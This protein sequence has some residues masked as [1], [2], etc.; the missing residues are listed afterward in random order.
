MRLNKDY[1]RLTFSRAFKAIKRKSQ[2]EGA[3][4]LIVRTDEVKKVYK[5]RSFI[6]G[7]DNCTYIKLGVAC[8]MDKIY[9]ILFEQF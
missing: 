6:T 5:M 7:I 2:V 3:P 8:T 4:I 9:R 1:N